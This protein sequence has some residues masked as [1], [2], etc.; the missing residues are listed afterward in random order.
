MSRRFVPGLLV[1]T[2]AT[3]LS[4]AAWSKGE[5]QGSGM[6]AANPK[7]QMDRTRAIERNYDNEIKEKRREHR[8]EHDARERRK[9]HDSRYER[10]Q[11][12]YREHRQDGKKAVGLAKQR[13]KKASQDQKELS[14]GSEQGQKT[15]EENSRKWWKFW[16]E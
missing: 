7:G 4:T 13:E 5:G 6:R 8:D 10:E 15:R 9:E 14:R 16:G 12:S 3:F 2:I 11:N 1:L